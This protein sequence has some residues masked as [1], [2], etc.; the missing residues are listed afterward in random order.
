M[1]TLHRNAHTQPSLLKTV[2]TPHTLHRTVHTSHTP[3]VNTPPTSQRI[4]D[5]PPTHTPSTPHALLHYLPYT[6]LF[7]LSVTHFTLRRTAAYNTLT[8]LLTPPM[9]KTIHFAFRSF[10]VHLTSNWQRDPGFFTYSP[11]ATGLFI[12][13]SGC[14]LPY[15]G[16]QVFFSLLH[17]YHTQR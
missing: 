2:H 10:T 15:T 13:F 3:T 11:P 1:R 4:A 5:T 8:P 6:V 7:T 17:L 14:K 12:R 16:L 9:H